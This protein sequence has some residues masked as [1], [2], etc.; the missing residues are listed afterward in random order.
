MLPFTPTGA[1]LLLLFLLAPSPAC[2][3]PV[4]SHH[5]SITPNNRHDLFCSS[6]RLRTLD[7]GSSCPPIASAVSQ[8]VHH[9]TAQ[10]IVGRRGEP[11]TSY[12]DA[13]TEDDW[14]EEEEGEGGVTSGAQDD[15]L[16]DG[17][18]ESADDE[19]GNDDLDDGEWQSN[20]TNP[21][22]PSSPVSDNS[23]YPTTQYASYRSTDS[24]SDCSTLA[25]LFVSLGGANWLNTDGWRD[26]WVGDTSFA[27]CDYYGVKCNSF[28]RVT[29]LDLDN[30]GL[31]GPLD[32]RVFGLPYL[33]RL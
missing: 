15:G 11:S 3:L 2:S 29:A 20:A 10:A 28:G 17:S 31:Q 5:P 24:V 26:S 14:E 7:G 18:D 6:L 22:T 16:F 23:T 4:T 1:F 32:D 9:R 19:G 8:A 13:E 12:D 21:V 30:N 33:N 25:S 27:C